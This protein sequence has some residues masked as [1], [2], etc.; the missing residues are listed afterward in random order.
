MEELRKKQENKRL[1][2]DNESA[3][4][5]AK[6][7]TFHYK[8]KHMQIMYHFI[9]SFVEYGQFKLENIHTS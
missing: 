5:I 2:C 1:Y 8:N 3:A 9:R 6:N 7:L 4:H